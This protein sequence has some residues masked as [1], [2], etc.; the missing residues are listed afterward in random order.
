M[1]PTYHVVPHSH[2]DREW[3]K[4]FE[5]F[6]AMLVEMIDD[7]LEIFRRDPQFRCFTLDGQ[8]VVL[9]D[10]L[11]VRPDRK[12]EIRALVAEGKIVTGP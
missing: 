3:Y 5:Q 6:R 12:E 11:A 9:E 4:S 8:T 10:Y 1:T 7:L 2:W